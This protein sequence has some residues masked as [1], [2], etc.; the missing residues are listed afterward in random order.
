MTIGKKIVTCHFK[1]RERMKVSLERSLGIQDGMLTCQRG[2]NGHMISAWWYLALGTRL[3]WQHQ[4][5]LVWEY[6][7]HSKGS[8]HCWF[9]P[10]HIT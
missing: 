5:R 6:N 2:G 8:C 4:N 1:G 9:A 7:A 3:E 10:E